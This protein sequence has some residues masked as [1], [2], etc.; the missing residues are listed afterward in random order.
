MFKLGAIGTCVAL[1][2]LSI[3]MG[4]VVMQ[5][6]AAEVVRVG[7]AARDIGSL[8][9]AF[10]RGNVDE[11]VVRQAFNPL[12]SPPPGTL[13]TDL[14]KIRG[15]LAESWHIS[16]DSRVWTFKLRPG[17]KWQ[18]GYGEVSAEDVKFTFDR[19]RD[20]KVASPYAA[21]FAMI[22]E[23]KVVD[24]LTVQFIL[25]APNAN[26][27]VSALMPRFGGYIV[28]KKAVEKLGANFGAQPVGSGAF[29]V[30]EYDPKQRVTA[31]A[32]KEY[33]RGEPKIGRL[34]MLLMPETAARTIAFV[35]GDLDIIEGARSPNW[36]NDIKNRKADAVLDALQPGSVQTMFFNLTKKPFDDLRVR[37]AIARALDYRIWERAY[38]VLAGRMWGPAP[39]EF[40]GAL[41]ESDLPADLK[42]SYD[43]ET[44]K[45]L[46][47]EAGLANGFSVDVFISEREDYRTNLLLVQDQLR[48]VGIQINLRVVDHTSY[49][50]DIAKDLNPL[51]V[52]STSQPPSVIPV[53]DA[54]YTAKA[55]VGKPGGNRNFS[56]YGEVG[57]KIDEKL[58]AATAETDPQRQLAFL[59]EIQLQI[60]RDLPMVPLQSLAVLY[61]RQPK[62][63]LGFTPTAGL[64]NYPLETAVFK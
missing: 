7:L 15:E 13:E 10:T 4:P 31:K 35:G 30:E 21:A 16:Q 5:A 14:G 3:V 2:A 12:V 36:A 59:R 44:A 41:R 52:Y 33:F 22:Q 63:D 23:V 60:M 56:H 6:Q 51:I 64:G 17:I 43:L 34:E 42:Y 9:P 32:F 1:S 37:Q 53:L 45:K 62:L 46:L 50:A 29:E 40:Y 55:V 25:D 11:F 20:P 18:K 48:R 8:D 57:T 58:E 39:V 54:F 47:A 27:H 19:L 24:P 38:G 26:F 61:V 49:H 28:P